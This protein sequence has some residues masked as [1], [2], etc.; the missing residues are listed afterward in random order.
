[1]VQYL[2][3]M[4]NLSCRENTPVMNNRS[5]LFCAV[6][7]TYVATVVRYMKISCYSNCRLQLLYEV[8]TCVL[9][10]LQYW[11]TGNYATIEDTHRAQKKI[12]VLFF[13]TPPLQIY[14]LKKSQKKNLI[15]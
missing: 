15:W 4:V 8:V 10:L 6:G 1:M 12:R 7:G 11:H 13:D 3:I 14:I 9:V 2:I 5:V